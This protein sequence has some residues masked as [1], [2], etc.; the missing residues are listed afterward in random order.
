M[1]RRINLN[2][3]VIEIRVDRSLI[4]IVLLIKI[5]VSCCVTMWEE[6]ELV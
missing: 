3:E 2:S 5:L 1:E 4:F 6:V